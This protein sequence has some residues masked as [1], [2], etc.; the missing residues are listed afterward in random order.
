M[1]TGEWKNA[2]SKPAMLGPLDSSIGPIQENS[3]FYLL[4][5]IS[6]LFLNSKEKIIHLEKIFM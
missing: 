6:I 1:N 3:N 5:E 4:N 2:V